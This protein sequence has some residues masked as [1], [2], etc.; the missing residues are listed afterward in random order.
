MSFRTDKQTLNDLVVFGN[1]R[2]KSIY[3]IFNRT[4]TRGGAKILEEMFLYP[5]SEADKINER[6]EVIRYF[7]EQ[8]CISVQRRN[9]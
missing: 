2:T 4:R 5:L 3:E 8:V 9:L 1:N 7:K 6:S